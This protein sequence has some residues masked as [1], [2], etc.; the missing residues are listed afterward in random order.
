[1][2]DVTPTDFKETITSLLDPGFFPSTDS[3]HGLSFE[4]LQQMVLRWKNYVDQGIFR[5]SVPTETPLGG[6]DKDAALAD[7]WTTPWPYWD[8]E[9]LA[10]DIFRDLKSS[11]LVIFKVGLTSYFP[12]ISQLLILSI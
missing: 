11:N 8:I 2:S 1:M 12:F 5:L 3:G 7:F 6:G 10:P 9:S 4:H